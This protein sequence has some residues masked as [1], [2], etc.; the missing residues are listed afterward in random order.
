MTNIGDLVLVYYEDSPA[1][2]ARI[3]DISADSKPDWYQV[4]LLILQI[5]VAE[6]VWILREAYINGDTFTM[7][8]KRIR[9]EKVK[10]ANKEEGRF[11]RS[12]RR[13]KKRSSHRN[14]KVISLLDRKKPN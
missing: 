13:S 10:V 7:N 12:D 2:F 6:T 1:F 4:K 3:E 11:Y 5:P 8:D 14:D 9:L